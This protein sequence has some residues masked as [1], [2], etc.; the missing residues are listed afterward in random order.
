VRRLFQEVMSGIRRPKGRLF[1]VGDVH[2]CAQELRAL[3]QQLP[4][5]RDSTVVFVGDYI[6]RGPD[7]RGVVDTVLDLSDYCNVVCLMGNHEL[8][9]HEFL[10]GSDPV[11]VARFVYNGGSSTL[12]SYADD[13]GHYTI[14]AEHIE[15]YRSLK[16]YHVDGE[17]C[18]VHAGLPVDVPDIDL[19]V[20]AEELVWMRRRPGEPD[21]EFSKIVVHGHSTTIEPEITPRRI[22][23]DTACVYGRKLTAMDLATK[24]VFQVPRMSTPEPTYLHEK[25]SRR[26]A[27]RFEGRVP[28]VIPRG[29]KTLRYETINYSEIGILMREVEPGKQPKLAQ[30]EQIAGTIGPEPGAVAFRGVVIRVDAGARYAVKILV[31]PPKI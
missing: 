10:D 2:G 30:G 11:L 12:A 21:P 28:V 4:I 23:I 20:H 3:V 18:F 24:Q 9:L 29:D 22:N 26:A 13:E 1:A 8:M 5:D 16:Y 31:E 27:V 25:G 14:P 6:D 19:D 17:Y 15:F 7:A